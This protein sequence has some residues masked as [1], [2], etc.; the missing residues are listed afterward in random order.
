MAEQLQVPF[1]KFVDW[2]QCAAVML[3]CLPLHN[4][5]TV[6]PVHEIFKRPSLV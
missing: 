2:W 5:G 1:E 4:S 6:P 3:L